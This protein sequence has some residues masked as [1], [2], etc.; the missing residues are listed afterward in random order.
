MPTNLNDLCIGQYQASMLVVTRL[1]DDCTPLTG[2]DDQARTRCFSQV[3]AQPQYEDGTQFGRRAA[4]GVRCWYVRDCDR[5]TQ[6]DVTF[7][8]LTWDWELIELM[9]SSAL[10]IGKTGGPWDG[11]VIGIY[12]P[13]P[14]ADCPSG[15]ST[16]VYVKAAPKGSGGICSSNAGF[17][18]YVRH[19]F[20]FMRARLGQVTMDDNEE[21]ILLNMQGFSLPNPNWGAGPANNWEGTTVPADTPYAAV[22]SNTLPS[23]QCGYAE[24]VA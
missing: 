10:A 1:D 18:S 13:G 12:A 6:W 22:F 17:P 8:I 21:G 3:D 9:T 14:D 16:E 23:D 11:D 5:L 15:I 2:D 4:D 24:T 20:P 19:L 7:T